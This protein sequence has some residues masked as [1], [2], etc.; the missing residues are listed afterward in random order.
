VGEDG[1]VL[2]TGLALI[3]AGL[4]SLGGF[5]TCV[6]RAESRRPD[7]SP[8]TVPELSWPARGWLAAAVAGLLAGTGLL[9][10][11]VVSLWGLL[12]G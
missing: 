9:M 4:L 2:L 12:S 10:A 7:L 8:A 3:L 6:A 5:T 11:H 1:A